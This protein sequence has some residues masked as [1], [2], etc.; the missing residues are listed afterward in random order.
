[1]SKYASSKIFCP[2]LVEA[3]M[4]GNRSQ[5]EHRVAD[6]GIFP[7]DERQP[8]PLND[9]GAGQVVMTQAL[10]C[11]RVIELA[12]QSSACRWPAYASFRSIDGLRIA[13]YFLD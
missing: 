10:R 2:E 5:V 11:Q 13:F 1:M 4:L 6:G 8:S 9:I 3:V 12:E 7:I